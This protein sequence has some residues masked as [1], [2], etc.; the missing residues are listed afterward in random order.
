MKVSI[1]EISHITGFSPATIS[2]ALNRKKGVNAQ[3]SAEIFR[4]AK[5]LGYISE[6]DITKIK[7][8]IYKRNGLIV[9]DTPFFPLMFDGVE[10]ECRERGYEM[11][12]L[13]LDSRH[14][15]YK[16]EVKK[17]VNDSSC[18]III[19][20]AELSSEEFEIFK[21]AKSPLITLDYWNSEMSCNGVIINNSDSA[22]KA[23]N[24]LIAKGHTQIGYLRGS[25]RINA[26]RTRGSGY[27]SAMNRAN[28]PI[29]SEYTVTLSTTM[30]GAFQDMEAYL[31]T[32]P[33]L[34]TAFFADN[35]MIALGAMR[36][37]TEA[38]YDI[39]GDISVIGFD[40]L[41]FCEIAV[42][43]LTSIRVPKKEMGRT[44]VRRLSQMIQE[45][46]NSI[47]KIQ[48]G[49]EFIERDSVKDI[50]KENK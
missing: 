40:D 10:T 21:T 19:L 46:N 5:E 25:F 2:N 39:P 30:D 16:E 50:R 17:L 22:I 11:T 24:Y 12:M 7:L 43:R 18:A 47:L 31:K 6:S 38:G 41:P 29:N 48:V 15:D 36:A 1:K 32:N 23:V 14:E 33:K 3:T 9:D 45:Q 13:Y 28:L 42:P 44:V 34:P 35:D 37:L 26:F 27:R 4:V 20:G 49:T 8:V